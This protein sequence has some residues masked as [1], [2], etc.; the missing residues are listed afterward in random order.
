MLTAAFRIITVRTAFLYDEGDLPGHSDFK[1]THSTY[2]GL[3]GGI[4][5][6][7]TLYYTSLSLLWALSL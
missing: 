4:G 5:L 6:W 2:I 7:G 3:F 1:H